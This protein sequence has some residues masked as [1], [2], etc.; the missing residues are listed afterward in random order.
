MTLAHD[1]IRPKEGEEHPGLRLG[2][3]DTYLIET[4]SYI[5]GRTALMET[6]TRR[7][8]AVVHGQSGLGKS[9]LL[10]AFRQEL[11]A[12]SI[13][14]S[15]NRQASHRKVLG[16][17]YR[18]LT[19]DKGPVGT[20]TDLEPLVLE[21]LKGPELTVV[22]VDEAQRLGKESVGLFRYLYDRYLSFPLIIAGSTGTWRSLQKDENWT[23][24]ITREVQ[25]RS[26]SE[27]DIL[28]SMPRYHEMWGRVTR[29][30]KLLA[31]RTY[32]HGRIGFWAN[33]TVAMRDMGAEPG[34]EPLDDDLV[35]QSLLEL[36]MDAASA[37]TLAAS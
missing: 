24:R 13:F 25:F 15:F 7:G 28:K 18:Q 36:P 19:G 14:L 35:R 32:A 33:L 4:N 8:V 3:E 12:R 23:S 6:V 9:F 10:K 30:A 22:I 11:S 21:L 20:G 31:D 37:E 2:L 1:A 34:S 29:D 5:L 26:M 27:D 17:M 16:E